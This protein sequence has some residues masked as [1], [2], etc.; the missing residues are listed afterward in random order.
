MNEWHTKPGI[1]IA[2]MLSGITLTLG[3]IGFLLAKHLPEPPPVE[4]QPVMLLRR[5]DLRLHD[6]R[7]GA[8]GKGPSW[9]IPRASF[10]CTED[11]P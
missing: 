1:F 7:T 2:G 3:T 10:T 8:E 11:R 6:H 4:A 5:V 9:T